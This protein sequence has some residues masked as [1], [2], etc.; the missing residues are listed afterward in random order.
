MVDFAAWYSEMKAKTE[1]SPVGAIMLAAGYS[2][3][4][5]GGGTLCWA[6]WT[7]ARDYM[8]MLTL[9]EDLDINDGSEAGEGAA[10]AENTIWV[11]GLYPLDEHE[12][13]I[14]DGSCEEAHGSAFAAE[15]GVTMLADPQAYI[16]GNVR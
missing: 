10:D 4:H 16:P 8:V 7:Q 3:Q 14:G 12:S 9:D 2:L 1:A 13:I 15:Q 11:V 5:N 6:K